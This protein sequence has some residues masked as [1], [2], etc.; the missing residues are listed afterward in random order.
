M[1]E[2]IEEWL[3]AVGTAYVGKGLSYYGELL[4]CIKDAPTV[5]VPDTNVGKWIPVSER[6][7]RQGERI[8]GTFDN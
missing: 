6:L 5:D 7:P 4:G 8:I 3:D 2:Q 1:I